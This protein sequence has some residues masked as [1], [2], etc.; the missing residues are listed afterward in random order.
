MKEIATGIYGKFTALGGGGAHNSLYLG[1]DGRLYHT[2]AL[3]TTTFPFCVFSF[4]SQGTE[5]TF[6]DEFENLVVQFSLFSTTNSS[7]EIEDL[8][9]KLTALYDW[10][11][12][13]VTGYSHLYMRRISSRLTKDDRPAWHY[14]IDYR[15]FVVKT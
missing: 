1:L 7:L 11:S 15:I 14:S 3:Q 4:V 12:L 2:Q 10:C 9:A 13:S 5:Y 8:R 6:T